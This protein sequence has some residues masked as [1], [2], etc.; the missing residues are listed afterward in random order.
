MNAALSTYRSTRSWRAICRHWTLDSWNINPLYY[1]CTKTDCLKS[2]RSTCGRIFHKY[3]PNDALTTTQSR[4][5]RLGIGVE[6]RGEGRGGE[7]ASNQMTNHRNSDD[8]GLFYSSFIAC[9]S[10]FMV[11]KSLY[12]H[13]SSVQF[14]VALLLLSTLFIIV[15]MQMQMLGVYIF[16][17]IRLIY[18]KKKRNNKIRI[19]LQ[20]I[21]IRYISYSYFYLWEAVASSR[22]AIFL[23]V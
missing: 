1:H 18:E 4:S 22:E 16:Y 7:G 3:Y 8:C 23:P 10:L 9:F 14:I 15:S 11:F 17:Q 5:V 2:F 6:G 12:A 20:S 13:Y 19:T 21:E